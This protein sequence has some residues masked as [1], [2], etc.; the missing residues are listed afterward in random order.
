MHLT[1]TRVVLLLLLWCAAR[2]GRSEYFVPTCERTLSRPLIAGQEHSLVHFVLLYPNGVRRRSLCGV[3]SAVRVG[4]DSPI[5][6]PV[7]LVVW[8]YNCT[9][10]ISQHGELVSRLWNLANS[11]SHRRVAVRVI[12][13][14]VDEVL[15]GTPLGA[16]YA[17]RRRGR[18][19]YDRFNRVNALRL[20][21]VHRHGGLYTDL[22]M[23]FRRDPSTITMDFLPLMEDWHRGEE[24]G[25]AVNSAPFQFRQPGHP[26]LKYM[27]KNFTAN[28]KGGRFG[29]QG[30]KLFTRSARHF[31]PRM[32]FRAQKQSPP[33]VQAI[34]CTSVRF[35]P[36]SEVS[37]IGWRNATGYLAS[38]G[39]RPTETLAAID[40]VTGAFIHYFEHIVAKDDKETKLCVSNLDLYGATPL[41]HLRQRY[42]PLVHGEMLSHRNVS[43]AVAHRHIC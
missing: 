2:L 31:C 17:D 41:Y 18:G 26:L 39:T 23:F 11:P 10:F 14:N 40:K 12:D 19:K 5:R 16:F 8:V 22:D 15:R 9:R 20:A 33:P 32:V 38:R 37:P 1:A 27:M 35:M 43:P 25:L 3:E 6:Q 21:L 7:T 29:Y 28:Y 4:I 34:W 42:C 24:R 36:M 30:P 13:L